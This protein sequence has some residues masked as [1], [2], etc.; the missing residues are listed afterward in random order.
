MLRSLVGSEM[1]IR[2]RST[3][4]AMRLHVHVREKTILVQCADGLQ[5]IQW[6]ASVGFCRYDANHGMEL[7]RPVMVKNEE[8]EAVDMNQ[9]VKNAF[10]DNA[11]VWILSQDEAGSEGV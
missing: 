2:D 4:I 11:H 3:G 10:D 5:K 7:G 1:C 6:L 9:L 8:G